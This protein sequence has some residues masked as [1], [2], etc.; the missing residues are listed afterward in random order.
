MLRTKHT[1]DRRSAMN[2][3]LFTFVGGA[4]GAWRV[5]RMERIVGASIADVPRVD[6]LSDQIPAPH[7]GMIWMLR[8]ITSNER[9]VTDAE[10]AQLLARQPGLG[11]AE[12]T[13]AALIPVRKTSTWWS[14]AQDVRRQ[15]FEEHS[16]HVKTGLRYLPAV[17]RRLHH[18]RD[19]GEDEPFDFLTWFEYA[20]SDADA[21]YMLLA[22]IRNS[23][24]WTY[25]E[26]EID[27]RLL[28]EP[29]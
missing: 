8:G 11:R 23:E 10:R 19:L 25:V 14:F 21:F 18:C 16:N 17:A 2:T 26:R 5:V 4:I 15:I 3:R 29:A 6:V 28:R 20:P 1:E 7:E 12:A 13:C 22:E 24:E 27:I 9:Y